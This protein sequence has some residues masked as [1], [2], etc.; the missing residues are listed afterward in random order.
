MNVKP[1]IS[2][3]LKEVFYNNNLIQ[4][5]LSQRYF[6]MA[7]R[8]G[9]RRAFVQ[10]VS[11]VD[12]SPVEELKDIECPVLIQWGREDQWIPLELSKIFIENIP[13]N[14]MI[15]YDECGHVPQEEIPFISVED[16]IDFLLDDDTDVIKNQTDI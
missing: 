9:N 12:W 11:A 4:P 6:D 13:D 2:K 8:K 16:A 7:R 1:L 15:V 3:S 14:R 5:E 10:M